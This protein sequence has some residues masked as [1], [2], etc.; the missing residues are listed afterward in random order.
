M[1]R[2]AEIH[3]KMLPNAARSLSDQKNDPARRAGR[4]SKSD[5]DSCR[6]STQI[7]RGGRVRDLP[8]EDDRPDRRRGEERRPQQANKSERKTL[9]PRHG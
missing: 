7:I 5:A 4:D 9:G 3:T 2:K 1:W 8:G 6:E